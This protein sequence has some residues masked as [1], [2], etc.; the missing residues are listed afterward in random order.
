M[1]EVPE[2]PNSWKNLRYLSNSPPYES[3]A[4]R[5]KIPIQM[6]KKS[7]Q[8]SYSNGNVNPE[9]FSKLGQMVTWNYCGCL[10][11][12]FRLGTSLPRSR[13]LCDVRLLVVPYQGD[14][15]FIEHSKY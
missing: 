2:Y 5:L 15:G 1:S 7:T 11:R 13:F 12:K 14:H 9:I 4:K 3:V 10:F 6:A 8:I